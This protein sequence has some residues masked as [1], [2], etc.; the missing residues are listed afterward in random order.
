MEAVLGALACRCKAKITGMC[1]G[2]VLMLLASS[3][4][5]ASS[6]VTESSLLMVPGSRMLA[7]DDHGHSD[8]D[9]PFITS[10]GSESPLEHLLELYAESGSTED[11]VTWLLHAAR[12]SSCFVVCSWLVTA[13][14][15]P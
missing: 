3:S 10:L 13:I 2:L 12:Y 8:V 14:V 9:T 11:A 1:T 6:S 4:A 7:A 15:S 5:A